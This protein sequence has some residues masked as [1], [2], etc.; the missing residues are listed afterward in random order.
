[1][2]P[3]THLGLPEVQKKGIVGSCVDRVSQSKC[4]RGSCYMQSRK[5]TVEFQTKARSQFI[6]KGVNAEGK[7]LDDKNPPLH[8]CP[9]SPLVH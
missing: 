6:L 5:G 7:H 2:H 4:D 1:M 3:S 9:A 8:E